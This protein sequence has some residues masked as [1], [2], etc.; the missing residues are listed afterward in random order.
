MRD[1]YSKSNKRPYKRE[2]EVSKTKCEEEWIKNGINQEGLDVINKWCK[3]DLAQ[4]NS[5]VTT[6]KLRKF[7]GEVKRIQSV[8]IDTDQGRKAFMMLKPKLAYA[9]GREK[10]NYNFKELYI[11][12]EAGI[13]Y[14]D[15]DGV[16][17]DKERKSRFNNFTHLFESI[18]AYHKFHGGKD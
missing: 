18:V 1:S 13:N 2:P 4:R 17:D 9:V 12:L 14:I 7:Y 16:I 8:G 10:K 15:I 5:E 3:N 11:F 6:S